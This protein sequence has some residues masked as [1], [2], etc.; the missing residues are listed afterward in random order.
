MG[1]RR[2]N[3][4]TS[5]IFCFVWLMVAP[6]SVAEQAQWQAASPDTQVHVLELSTSQ[7]C[8]SCP[9]ADRWLL[10]TAMKYPDFKTVIPLA[11]HVTYW[12]RLG[13][14]DEFGQKAFDVRQRALAREERTSVYTPGVFLNSKEFRQWRYGGDLPLGKP[15]GVLS[16][17]GQ[18][19]ARTR[20]HYQPLTTAEQRLTLHTAFLSKEIVTAVRR[21]ENRGRTLREGYIVRAYRK[22]QM[23]CDE[24]C[25]VD[26][27]LNAPVE[28][29]V[30]VAWLTD[31]EGRHVQAAGA[32]F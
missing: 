28:S 23:S 2:M 32:Y 29:D 22:F 26:T 7:G 6:L 27:Q 17:E 24:A 31:R 11:F 30:L 10:D 8:S 3:Y 15:T 1:P 20:F 9:P 19:D 16:F 13:W 4:K 14:R 5:T 25:A 18:N 12:D 21:G